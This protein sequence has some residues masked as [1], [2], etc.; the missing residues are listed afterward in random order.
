MRNWS[1]PVARI[2]GT[3]VRLHLT[4]VLL[5]IYVWLTEAAPHSAT[6]G[7]PLALVAIVLGS[8]VLHELMHALAG[9]HANASARSIVLLPIGGVPLLDESAQRDTDP[10]REIRIAL[11]GP[12]VNLALAAVIA[13]VGA[14]VL[15]QRFA[16]LPL[17]HSSNLLRSAIW[18]NVFLAVFNLLPAYPL[19]GGRLLRIWFRR[20]LDPVRATRR[21]V[22]VGQFFSMAF[23][24]MGIWNTWL[25]LVGFFLF[26]GTQLEDRSAVFQSVLA[27]V[28]MDDVMLTDFATLSPAD[29]LEDALQKAVHSLQD[30]FPVIRG[31][32][33]VGVISRQQILES[34]RSGGNAYVQ[35]AMRRAFEVAERSDS[36]ASAFHK[37]TADGATLIPVIEQERLV[38]IVTLQNLMH[39][40]ALLAE[41]RR[42]RR[43]ESNQGS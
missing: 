24:F 23:L 1:I 7:R 2:F 11:A 34:L 32:D 26:V 28:S 8:V 18:V 42:L 22:M 10:A 35:S 38:G 40:M 25:M 13:A 41:T 20:S 19:D 15:P 21:A 31:S 29:T 16:V 12:A 39:S 43:A 37:I 30:D 6:S 36:L 17:V 4:F 3:E 9:L 14:S 27:S 33:L 5:L